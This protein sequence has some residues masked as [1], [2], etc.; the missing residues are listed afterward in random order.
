MQDVVA[1]TIGPDG[2]ID[3]KSKGFMTMMK[4]GG[5]GGIC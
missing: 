2:K 1:S 4:M 3:T 5:A